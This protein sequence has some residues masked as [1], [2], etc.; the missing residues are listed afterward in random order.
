VEFRPN[1]L[2]CQPKRLQNRSDIR[3]SPDAATEHNVRNRKLNVMPETAS[4]VG[5]TLGRQFVIADGP[6]YIYSNGKREI[7][8]WCRCECGSPPRLLYN[9]RLLKGDVNACKHCQNI[10]HGHTFVGKISRTFRA[11]ASMINRCANHKHKQFKDWGGRGIKVCERWQ[12][13]SNFLA[14]MGECPEGLTLDRWPN[15]NGNYEPGNC[16]WATRKQQQRNMRSNRILTVGNITDCLA[17]LCE[18]FSVDNGTV[19]ARL[20]RNWTVEEAFMGRKS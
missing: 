15:N 12:T 10:Q 18:R 4:L 17:A 20:R 16:R 8:S 14:D 19:R 13:F 3:L 7:R 1:R 6:D 2:D 9:R 11:W 5:R